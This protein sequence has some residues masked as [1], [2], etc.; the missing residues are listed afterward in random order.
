M[1]ITMNGPLHQMAA[2]TPT[3]YLNDSCSVTELTYALERGTV[4][5]TSN[6]V[7]VGNVLKKEMPLWRGWIARAIQDN[8][9]LSETEL[10][11]KVYQELAITAAK[12]L[13]PIFEQSG[14]KQG[15][16]SIQ[17]DPAAFNNAETILTQA[18]QFDA[19]APNMQIKLPAT[20]AGMSTVETLTYEGISVN[21]TVSFSV[22]QVI[23]TAERVERGLKRRTMEG[24]VNSTMA[25]LAT[26]MVGRTDDWLKVVAK[27]NGLAVNQDHLEW[28][29][30]ACFKHAYRIFEERGYQTQLLSAAYRNFH[31]WTEFVGGRVSLTIPHEWQVKFNES[32]INPVDRMNI[33]VEADVMDTLRSVP[34]FDKSFE[35]H[36]M[37]I[38]E[39]D[40]YGPVVRTLRSFIEAWHGFVALIRD[41]QLPN[42]D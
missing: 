39:F 16:L 14:G 8:P 18:R 6:P 28:G 3:Q 12:L 24:K 4:G 35:E 40:S 38:E 17:T 36:G 27:K 21:V 42:P 2:T 5:A 31:H 10:G 37:K 23:A 7:I 11:W 29:G 13:M 22:P 19:L 15:R 33:P 32:S 34:D 41:I 30:V 26:M 1:T 9:T 20:M 25:P